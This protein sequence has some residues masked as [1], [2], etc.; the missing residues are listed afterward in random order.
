M[1][2]L[3]LFSGTKSI[4]KV[5][6]T[7]GWDAVSLDIDSTHDPDLCMCI[8]KFDQ[9]QYDP[10][11]FDFIWASCP[12]EAYSIARTVAKIPRDDAMEASDKLLVKTR[13]IIEYFG[14]AY[15]IENPATSGLWKRDVA[16]S[17]EAVI[18]SYCCFGYAYRKDTKLASNFPLVLPRCPGKGKCPAMCE[19][20]HREHAQKGG[21]GSTPRYHSRDELH[22][23]PEGLV[24]EI[25]RHVNEWTGSS[26]QGYA[27]RCSWRQSLN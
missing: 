3:E 6:Q 17:L 11:H 14:C 18:T 9:T 7:L 20:Q 21:G 12:C 26:S 4:S 22:S 25:Y 8:M 5:A 19:S 24:C 27:P 23:I 16:K 2:L 13:Q 15:C 1:R 10:D